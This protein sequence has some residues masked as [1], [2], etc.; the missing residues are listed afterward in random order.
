LLF[1]E[2]KKYF[3][4]MNSNSFDLSKKIEENYEKYCF[5]KKKAFQQKSLSKKLSALKAAAHFAAYKVIGQFSDNEIE[6][7]LCEISQSIPTS[8][9]EFEKGSI[10][11]VMTKCYETG[12]HT[13]VVE[14][15]IKASNSSESHSLYLV[16]QGKTAVPT[17]LTQVISNKKGEIIYSEKNRKDLAKAQE[18]RQRASQYQYVVL[19]VHMYDIVPLLAF[20]TEDFKRPIIFYN[21]AEH[22]FWV[23]VSISDIV[24][25][26]NEAAQKFSQEYRGIKKSQSKIVKI[27]FHCKTGKIS[28]STARHKL[29]IQEHQSLFLGIGNSYRFKPYDDMDYPRMVAEILSLDLKNVYIIVGTEGDESYWEKVRSEFP[30]NRLIFTGLIKDKDTFTNIL[31]ACDYYIEVFPFGSETSSFEAAM[32]T[33]YAPLI[34]DRPIHRSSVWKKSECLYASVKEIIKTVRFKKF[35]DN[36]C[37]MNLEENHSHEAVSK[38]IQ[39]VCQALPQLHKIHL[40]FKTSFHCSD[41]EVFLFKCIPSLRNKNKSIYAK[42][43]RSL[44]KRLKL[45]S[46]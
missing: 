30:K 37:V 43:K 4:A 3:D 6:R 17:W 20:G 8:S 29:G 10:L 35:S 13:R 9:C 12:G 46:L 34:L 22:M 41:Y 1:E 25:D 7:Q 33:D 18:L 21:H 36:K 19:H 40:D 5:L 14:N 26:M 39:E 28:K 45:F 32:N 16:N 24:V 23:R 38:S 31:K 15:W 2:L 27:P 42:L 44:Y 11:H